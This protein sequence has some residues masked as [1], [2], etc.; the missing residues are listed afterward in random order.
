M[1][2]F[3]RALRSLCFLAFVV[4]A[5]A[6]P[7]DAANKGFAQQIDWV[8]IWGGIFPDTGIPS[9]QFP[10]KADIRNAVENCG[11]G[12][13]NYSKIGAYSVDF[14][15]DGRADY[16]TEARGYFSQGYNTNTCP[17]AI[18][19]AS[20]GCN[21]SIYVRGAT[22]Q[23]MTR[24]SHENSFYNL[25]GGNK[26]EE[27][28]QGGENKASTCPAD[29]ADN[30]SCR[31]D[32]PAYSDLCPQLFVYNTALAYDGPVFDWSFIGFE[33]FNGTVR[34]GA[35]RDDGSYKYRKTFND[36]P[37][38]VSQRSSQHCTLEEMDRNNNNVIE[39]SETCV[40]YLQH[41]NG[42]FQDLYAPATYKGSNELDERMTTEAYSCTKARVKEAAPS[43]P[44]SCG[45]AGIA[46]NSDWRAESNTLKLPAKTKTE[47][48]FVAYQIANFSDP[49][50]EGG[51]AKFLC[52][53]YKNTSGKDLMI[54]QRTDLELASF[55]KALAAGN[56]PN[57]TIGECSLRFTNWSGQT[58]CPPLS[59]DE[60]RWISAQRNCQRSTSAYATCS[61]CKDIT[62]PQIIRGF[63]HQCTF[64]SLCVGP[65]C[66]VGPDGGDCLAAGA[67]IL[68][69][70]GSV[71]SI[72]AIKIGDSVMGFDKN[73]PLAA[74]KAAKVK[75]VMVSDKMPMIAIN[76]T[77]VSPNHLVSI[78]KGHVVRAA[79]IQPG[80]VLVGTSGQPVTVRTVDKV[81]AE[82]SFN[83]DLDGAD[84]FIA[85][86]LRVM[87]EKLK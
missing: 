38:F 7:A 1:I 74:P 59:C 81:E 23:I 54:P 73:A 5:T 45:N 82:K 17:I 53:E 12:D 60:T 29:P 67:K 8:A 80:T 76:G 28:K 42:F 61:V 22:S 55:N 24:P 31:S 72:E 19:S 47:T 86:G 57:V 13:P 85:D 68:M 70:D 21:I 34:E 37:V 11:I 43:V 41:F 18:C 36:N 14:N 32:C 49:D 69:A 62:D 58:S 25:F 27:T 52:K 4:T 77:K 46:Y 20:R 87:K 78:E 30:K 26:G 39:A 84:G 3:G 63:E 40:K 15:G 65:P 66:Q 83:L 35:K 44:T 71:K 50:S 9:S 10:P 51:N 79:R 16:V 2:S 64:S 48:G 75:A 33:Q 56:I 6:T